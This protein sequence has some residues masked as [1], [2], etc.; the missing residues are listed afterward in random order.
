MNLARAL[1]VLIAALFQVAA[2]FAPQL[3]GAGRSVGEAVEPF[4]TPLVPAGWAFAIW[5][6][7]FALLG[8]FA[9]V[10]FLRRAE[11]GWA[12]AGWLALPA[13]LGNGLFGLVQPALGPGLESFLLLEVVLVFA[14]AASLAVKRVRPQSLWDGAAAV[15][16][17]ALAGWVSI[18]SAAG[19]SVLLR[20]EGLAPQSALL[21]DLLILVAFT[22]IAPFL[23]RRLAAWAY[24]LPI[25]WGLFG[26][27]AAGRLPAPA[28]GVVALSAA[29][30]LLALIRAKKRSRS[31]GLPESQLARP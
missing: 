27:A 10:H 28:L 4:R 25:L 18:A 12:R 22:A 11:P 31:E 1:L 21:P 16:L 6:V 30:I 19:L 14:L 13:L 26:I 24:V 2:G 29:L 7:L 17:P 23:A 5:G 3:F 9:V 20:A 15:S 8:V